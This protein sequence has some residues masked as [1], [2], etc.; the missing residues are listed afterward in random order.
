MQWKKIASLCAMSAAMAGIFP[1]NAYAVSDDDLNQIRQSIQQLE[2]RHEEDA[3]HIKELENK[4]KNYEAAA[5]RLASPAQAPTTAPQP[6]LE[7]QASAIEPR[8]AA[9]PASPNSFNPAISAVLMG[10]YE[11]FSRNPNQ[12]ITGFALGDQAKSLGTQGFSLG[13]SEVGLSSNIDPYLYGELIISYEPDGTVG[14]ENGFIQTTGLPWGLTVK[15]GRFFSAIGYM[16][17]QHAHAWDFIDAPLP[18]RAFLNTQLGDDG[19]Q[20]RWLAPTDTFLQIGMEGLRGDQFPSTATHA[21]MG[22]QSVFVKAGGDLDESN[23]WLSSLAYYHGDAA[24]RQTNNDI[25]TGTTDLGIAGLV[26]KWAPNGNPVETNLKLQGEYFFQHQNGNFDS[27]NYQ[28]NQSGFYSQAVYQF[29]PR[30]S[31]GA[32]FDQLS[33]GSIP[34]ALAGSTLDGMG[35]TPRRYSGALTYNTS[36]FGRFRL[37][38]NYDQS[39]PQV[40]QSVLF[41]YTVEMGAHGAHSY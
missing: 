3:Q 40:N 25:F 7:T 17:E 29:M 15:G 36:E 27:V 8:T 26:W 22:A 12:S 13:E 9:A 32:R 16:N 37:Q 10:T 19:V 35:Q 20:I 18:Y 41:N 24:N 30:W 2:Q 33:P 23:S 5:S 11:H 6:A 28:G 4:L 14:V 31:V 38:Y 1:L 34:M 39:A 21:G